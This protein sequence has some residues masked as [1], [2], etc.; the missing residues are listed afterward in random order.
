MAHQFTDATFEKEVLQNDKL[1]VVDFWAEWCGP[2]KQMNPILEEL[3]AEFGETALIG[4]LNVDDNPEVP[5]T[6][7]IR[8]IPTL[9]AFK[10]GVEVARI[11]GLQPKAALKTKLES[12]V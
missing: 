8:G 9:I 1:T 12:L 6:Y 7:G 11:V 2:C 10:G 3:S 4:K 5:T